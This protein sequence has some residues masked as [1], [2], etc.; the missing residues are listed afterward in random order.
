M[1]VPAPTAEL[2]TR[3]SSPNA[4]APPWS[5]VVDALERAEIFWLSTVRRDGRPH[6]T[7]LPGY[8][9]D[10]S[11]YFCTGPAEQKSKNIEAN[12]HCVLTTGNDRS[13][14]G[15]TWWWRA[16]QSG[17]RRT[18][19]SDGWRNLGVEARVGVRRLRRSLPPPQHRDRRH[20]IRVRR[21]SEEGPRLRQG[22]TVQLSAGAGDQRRVR[23]LA[24]DSPDWRV[25]TV[26]IATTRAAAGS[27]RRAAEEYG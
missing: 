13:A 14:P 10:G 21:R 19:Y 4:T 18:P 5:D 24:A 8:W 26:P 6:V 3:F 15:S 20:R 11:L 16:A 22:R 2:D 9:L 12:P 7:P 17:P 1:S 23:H 27:R 25:P